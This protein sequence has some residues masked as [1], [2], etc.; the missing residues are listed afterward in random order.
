[1]DSF[2]E[3]TLKLLSLPTSLHPPCRIVAS[4]S[5]RLQTMEGSLKQLKLV[6]TSLGVSEPGQGGTPV[7]RRRGSTSQHSNSG[8]RSSR[9]PSAGPTPVLPSLVEAHKNGVDVTWKMPFTLKCI[10]TF[11]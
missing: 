5:S 6:S 8:Q 10:G 3:H 1:M 4:L 11:R 2:K 7:R 9:D